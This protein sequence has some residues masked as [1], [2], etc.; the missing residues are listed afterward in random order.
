M[1][2]DDPRA[3][4]RPYTNVGRAVVLKAVRSLLS[5]FFNLQ[6]EM[7]KQQFVPGIYPDEVHKGHQVEVTE[8]GYICCGVAGGIKILCDYPYIGE[9]CDGCPLKK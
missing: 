6:Q 1:A 3:I 2:F 4:K 7:E 9:F 8:E 5:F